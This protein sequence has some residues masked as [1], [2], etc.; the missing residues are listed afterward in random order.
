MFSFVPKSSGPKLL[1]LAKRFFNEMTTASGSASVSTSLPRRTD[2]VKLL[3]QDPFERR[4]LE[5]KLQVKQLV[6]DQPHK[7]TTDWLE[8]KQHIKLL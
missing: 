7:K 3:L 4:T 2:L 1:V 8:W 5:G 6:P